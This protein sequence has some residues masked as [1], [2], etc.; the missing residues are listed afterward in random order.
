M[1]EIPVSKR[2]WSDAQLVAAVAASLSWRGVMRELG[3]CVT[4]AGAIRGVR[5]QVARLGLDTSH[6][7]GQRRW[8][9]AQL[10][11]A[12]A[13]MSSWPEL[14]AELGLSPGG[15]DQRVRVKA[16][17]ARLGLDLSRL[18][19]PAE[20]TA[21][22]RG[23]KLDLRRLRDSG[24]A[25]AAMWFMLCGCNSAFPVEP[26]HYDLL[27]AMPAGIKRIQ[28]KTTTYYG[29]S[30]WLIQ[31]G[32]RPYSAGNRG[33]LMPYDP[34]TLDFFFIIDGDLTMYLIPSGVL[35]GRVQILLRHYASYIVGSIGS[36]LGEPGP[37]C[38]IRGAD[39]WAETSRRRCRAPSAS[40]E[41]CRRR[42]RR[43]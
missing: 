4:S 12:V 11:Q 19:A 33:L 7:T 14:V 23:L 22:Q 35:A 25:I 37:G 41:R 15:G 2:T 17:A 32:R 29:K 5:R 38:L 6:F 26:A 3:L 42:T 10:R 36:L 8:S 39:E 27:A 13:S 30:G 20:P 16:H 28:V 21:V 31:V 18:A 24:T 43:R 40:S 1:A 9:D 34:D